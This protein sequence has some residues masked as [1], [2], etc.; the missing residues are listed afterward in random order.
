[1]QGEGLSRR[2]QTPDNLLE[3]ARALRTN[4]TEAERKLWS[5]LR[6]GRFHGLKFRRQVV[7]SAHYIAD[8]VHAK[9]KLIIELDGSQH[10]DRQAYDE[11]RT[12]FLE[13]EG[14]RV[15]RFWNNDVLQ[16]M[17]G[18]LETLLAA[19]NSAPLPGASRLSLPPEGEGR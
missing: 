9:S 18:V 12:Q 15:I 6:A 17:D 13:R 16:N 2:G 14:Y 5:R 11:R 3:Y 1:L 8:F 19:V 4:Q 7:F 10:A